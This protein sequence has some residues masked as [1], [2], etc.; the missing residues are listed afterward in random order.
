MGTQWAVISVSF[1]AQWGELYGDVGA[2][3]MPPLPCN[4]AVQMTQSSR[5]FAGAAPRGLDADN[6]DSPRCA[7]SNHIDQ[8]FF[9]HTA[10]GEF[11]A[12]VRSL[13]F[14]AHLLTDTQ[15]FFL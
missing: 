7:Q 10:C 13:V 1:K 12:I 14:V 4:R 9:L 3:L 5:D 11:C 15:R 8:L 2:V 6:D